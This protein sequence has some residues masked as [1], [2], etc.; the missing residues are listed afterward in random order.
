MVHIGGGGL[1]RQAAQHVAHKGQL[2]LGVLLRHG[3]VLNLLV[4]DAL[5]L[6]LLLSAHLVLQIDVAKLLTILRLAQLAQL[7]SGL[8]PGLQPLHSVACTVLTRLFAHLLR[9]QT[10]ALVGQLGLQVSLLLSVE[11]LLRVLE[12]RVLP[13]CLNVALLGCQVT[14]GFRLHD[15]CTG[16]AKRTRANSLTSTLGSCN[17]GLSLGFALLNVHHTLHVGVHVLADV[18]AC[19]ILRADLLC[20]ELRG[21]VLGPHSALSCQPSQTRCGIQ[22]GRSAHIGCALERLLLHGAEPRNVLGWVFAERRV[23]FYAAGKLLPRC[24]IS[25]VV[26]QLLLGCAQH[27]FYIRTRILRNAGV[28][29]SGLRRCGCAASSA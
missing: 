28:V 14:C 10:S 2:L 15:A 11:L 13:L 25:L 27:R 17:I 1:H 19:V 20:V 8:Q 7:T 16:A 26:V 23:A 5:L 22:L 6:G 4:Q 12:R 29:D 18:L 21:V 3:I 24:W 9:L